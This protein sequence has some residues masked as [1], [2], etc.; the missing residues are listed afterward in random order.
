MPNGALP[1]PGGAGHGRGRTPIFGQ[2]GAAPIIRRRIPAPASMRRAGRA[3]KAAIIGAVAVAVGAIAAA[4]ALGQG[5]IQA[6]PSI[7]DNAAPSDGT[8]VG[9]GLGHDDMPAVD[10]AAKDKKHYV[11]TASDSP[12]LPP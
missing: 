5:S 10:D 8:A 2:A 1:D 12:D 7:T 3:R 9:V 4:A 6:P 11:I